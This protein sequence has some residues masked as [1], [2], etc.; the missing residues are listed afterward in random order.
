MGTGIITPGG[1]FGRRPAASSVL[2][3]SFIDPSESN[4]VTEVGDTGPVPSEDGVGV[5]VDLADADGVPAGSLESEI[6]PADT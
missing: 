4:D 1:A 2:L 5:G 3:Q 6:K